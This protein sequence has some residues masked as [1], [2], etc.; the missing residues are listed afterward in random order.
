MQQ[1]QTV[2][3]VSN[4]N[5]KQLLP[6]KMDTIAQIGDLPE[7]P[8]HA[9]ILSKLEGQSWIELLRELRSREG[10]FFVPVFYHGDVADNLQHLFD[11]P[12]DERLTE[13]ATAIHQRLAL[14][15]KEWM[16]LNDEKSRLMSYMHS[17]PGL[18]MQG[19]INYQSPYALEF[20]LFSVLFAKSLEFD[21]WGF[22]QILV[23]RGFLEQ[24]K[25]L[26]EIQT[27]N[28]CDSGL[29]N[30]KRNC[31]GCK[32]IDIKAQ[33]FVH[34]FS[35]GKIGP[36]PE[37]LR[38]E[39]LL[40][41]GCNTR[42]LELGVDYEKPIEDKLCNKCG[43]FFSEPELNVV[44]LVC[45]KNYSLN[46][47]G[48]RRLY[49]YRLT[50]HAEYLVRGVKKSI[51]RNFKQYFK[52]TDYTSFLSTVAWQTKLAER[53]SSIYFCVLTL[54]II[55]E[56]D[57]VARQGEANAERLLSQLFIALRQIFR[58]SDLASRHEEHMYF[59]LPMANQDGCMVIVE[60]IIKAVQQLT[61]EEIGRDLRVGVSH[62]SSDEIIKHAFH[63]DA[64][65]TELI[66]RMVDCNIGLLESK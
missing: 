28:S 6:L 37:F 7:Q 19:Y 24:N 38:H 23:V 32:S 66:A 46:E 27:C 56:S 44:C 45:Q 15:D 65:L 55:N 11:G 17:R 41:S 16:D 51:F 12:A 30:L 22:L 49:E 50:E 29:L 35:C 64:L 42:L 2:W 58:E 61:E 40:C 62:I 34:C 43:H 14:I 31:P 52:L 20:P 25:L 26:E 47:V 36:V 53:Y 39:R 5:E 4:I 57:L 18:F 48:S 1:Q 54:N 63:G 21:A 8:P 59:L 60:R 9:V 10:Y 33:K 13:R 3:V